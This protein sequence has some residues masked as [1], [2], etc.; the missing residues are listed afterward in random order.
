MSDDLNKAFVN[1]VPVPRPEVYLRPIPDPAWLAGFTSGEGC[2]SIN[3]IA[4]KTNLCGHQVQLKF[5]LTQ[6]SRDT[7][8]MTSLINYLNCGSVVQS[9]SQGIVDR[10]IVKF[11]VSNFQDI[12]RT[13]LPLFNRYPIQGVKAQDFQDF[14]K[15]AELMKNKAH[16]T[17]EGLDLIKNIKSGMNKGRKL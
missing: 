7:L 10:D 2:F 5:I 4:S 6:H 13:I 8:L 14:C 17:P 11:V 1:I 3:V 9:R 15:V 12:T 16:L